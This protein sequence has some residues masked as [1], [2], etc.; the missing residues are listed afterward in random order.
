M[1][2]RN[3]R[4]GC[5]NTCDYVYFDGKYG[6]IVNNDDPSVHAGES[7]NLLYAH[8]HVTRIPSYLLCLNVHTFDDS[9]LT[10]K[11]LE[12]ICCG[13]IVIGTYVNQQ[14]SSKPSRQ[15]FVA[16]VCGL[17]Q[18]DKREV[19][20]RF[21][22]ASDTFYEFT[23]GFACVQANRLVSPFNCVLTQ[24]P[25][26]TICGIPGIR[27]QLAWFADISNTQFTIGDFIT[28]K[29]GNTNIMCLCV[30]V[31]ITSDVNNWRLIF[32]VD[33]TPSDHTKWKDRLGIVMSRT[34]V[35]G[36]VSKNIDHIKVDRLPMRTIQLADLVIQH[37]RDVVGKH[38]D[39][40]G[41][42]TTDVGTVISNRYKEL[43][44]NTD[45]HTT[46]VTGTT[47]VL[48]RC[49]SD[50]TKEIHMFPGRHFNDAQK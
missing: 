21:Q 7:L 24:S 25:K 13:D 43:S 4:C 31:G 38:C 5:Q 12:S 34:V 19:V 18:N 49:S 42:I 36:I 29:K 2:K 45:E 16:V 1:T 44:K 22:S 46:F 35:S 9:G 30:L 47:P 33:P 40:G 6:N 8:H 20:V 17:T 41:I 28:C 15:I 50:S 39:I 48:P 10:P 11:D 27:G 3:H 37:T 23:G 32:V 14:N 26:H